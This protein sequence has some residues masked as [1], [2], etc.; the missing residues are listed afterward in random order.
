MISGI[1]RRHAKL[2]QRGTMLIEFV[3][4]AAISG[5]LGAT[6]VGSLFQLQRTTIEGGAQFE[7]TTEVQRATRWVTR[8]VHRAGSTTLVDGGPAVATATFEWS[9]DTGDHA[10]T[11]AL[12][13]ETLERTCDGAPAIVARRLSGLSFTRVGSLITVAFTVTADS[14]PD[15]NEPVSM[16]VALGRG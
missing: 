13:G 7:V 5:L 9:D 10:C 12:D 2:G 8:D 3:V 16:Y 15:K 14:R 11:Y 1:T 4:A 6:V